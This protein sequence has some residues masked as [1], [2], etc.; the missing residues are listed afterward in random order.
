MIEPPQVTGLE[1]FG[2]SQVT[3]HLQANTLPLKPWEVAWALPHRIKARFDRE[4]SQTPYSHRMP[5]TRPDNPRA[6]EQYPDGC[7]TPWACPQQKSDK[8]GNVP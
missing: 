8:S 1:A 3:I 6:P 2:E 5:I 7:R 4:G